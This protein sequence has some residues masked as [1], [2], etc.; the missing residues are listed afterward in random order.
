[1]AFVLGDG[2]EAC[3]AARDVA[4]DAIGEAQCY[5][6]RLAEA[7]ADSAVKLA[8]GAEG[9]AL[10]LLRQCFDGLEWCHRLF[11]LAA[12][13]AGRGGPEDDLWRERL[14]GY[15]G[16][17][18]EAAGALGDRDMVR[19]GDALRFKLCPELTGWLAESEALAV[20]VAARP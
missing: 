17:L 16:A 19:L 9:E 2:A 20:A 3:R 10:D 5:V 13:F 8:T 15:E 4:C 7:L 12:E 14:R 1:M 18:A 6:P 11:A